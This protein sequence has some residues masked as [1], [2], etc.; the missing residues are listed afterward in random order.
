MKNVRKIDV[1]LDVIDDINVVHKLNKYLATQY[2]TD[3]GDDSVVNY[4]GRF[5]DANEAGAI[6]FVATGLSRS[7]HIF[8]IQKMEMLNGLNPTICYDAFYLYKTEDNKIRK[9]LLVNSDFSLKSKKEPYLIC[10]EST[11][12]ALRQNV[13]SQVLRFAEYDLAKKYYTSKIIGEFCPFGAN[14]NI[15]AAYNFYIKNGYK[16]NH[17]T[18]DLSKKIKP[19][20]ILSYGNMIKREGELTILPTLFKLYEEARL[21]LQEETRAK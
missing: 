3:F 15:E 19:E 10:I 16:I 12:F 14:A 20:Q 18:Y 21:E 7:G 4:S 8:V 13:A 17:Q 5:F 1:G 6:Q 2:A 9:K 11:D